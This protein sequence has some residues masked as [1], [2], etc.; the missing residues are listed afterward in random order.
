MLSVAAARCYGLDIGVVF[1]YYGWDNWNWPPSEV[2]VALVARLVG[3]LPPPEVVW[4][5][6]EV[7]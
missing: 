7:D 4:P 3:V 1:W 2:D 6:S 5:P